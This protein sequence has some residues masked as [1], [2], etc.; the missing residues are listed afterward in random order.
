MIKRL[1]L[2]GYGYCQF[3]KKDDALKALN[4]LDGKNF[5]GQDLVV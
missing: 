1:N 2:S 5:Y 4:E 3:Y